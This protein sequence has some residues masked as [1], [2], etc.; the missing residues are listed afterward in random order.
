MALRVLLVEDNRL[1]QELVRDLLEAAQHEVAVANDGAAFRALIA[2]GV[3]PDIVVMDILL[4]D[5]DGVGLLRWLRDRPAYDDVPVLAV[6]AQVLAGDAE[7][8]IA[9]GFDAVI[10]KPID[11]R[12]IVAEIEGRGR[13]RRGQ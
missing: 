13:V 9:A 6:T 4:P 10:G 12:R 8:F 2:G 7:R 5:G 11:T 1:N 3:R